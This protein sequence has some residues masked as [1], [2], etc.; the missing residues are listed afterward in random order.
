MKTSSNTLTDIIVNMG[1]HGDRPCFSYIPDGQVLPSETLSF[2]EVLDRALRLATALSANGM[3]TGDRVA[4]F[5][6]PTSDY[7]TSY[8]GIILA[9][10]VVA[11]INHNFKAA[12]LSAYLRY[13]EPVVLIFDGEGEEVAKAVFLQEKPAWRPFRIDMPKISETAPVEALHAWQPLHLC[14]SDW[15]PA[16]PLVP[17]PEDLAVILHTSGTT[18][19]PKGVERTQRAMRAF[20]DRWTGFAWREEDTLLS[21]LPFYHQS[22]SLAAV[23]PMIAVGG[24]TVQWQRFSASRFWDVA[25]ANKATIANIIPPAPTYLLMQPPSDQDRK[26]TLEWVVIGGRTDHWSDF[27]ERFGVV[28]HSPYGSTETTYVT[29]SGSRDTPGPSRAELLGAAPQFYAGPPIPDYEEIRIMG[30][31]GP[32]GPG[33][34][35]EIQVR[36]PAVFERYFR[37]PEVTAQV[38][39]GDWFKTGDIGYLREDNHLFMIDR[40]KEVIRRASEN[41]SPQE[42]EIA[43]SEHPAVNEC[44][45]LGVTDAIRGQEILVCVVP[46]EGH[47]LSPSELFAHC[48]SR[49]SAFKVPR[50]LEIWQSLPRTGTM[51]VRKEELRSAQ[52]KVTRYDRQA[53][54][55]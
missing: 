3:Q 20:I 36:G 50:Y 26:H 35:G 19:L 49:L 9:G 25:D 11:P 6:Q 40:A 46:E 33:V 15:Q 31:D 2:R 37:L 44:V 43:L 22:G 17:R 21:Y 52:S 45:A 24:H 34:P 55:P 14:W 38:F 32:V 41:I 12:E 54:T 5:A 47:E 1:L 16:Q 51:K 28:S 8:L 48:A 29:I 53:L 27:Q 23:L 4:M 13:I 30:D 10:G 42:I 39:D 7:L 18:A